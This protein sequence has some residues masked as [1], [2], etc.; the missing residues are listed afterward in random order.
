MSPDGAVPDGTVVVLV[1]G[2]PWPPRAAV[3]AMLDRCRPIRTVI[4]AD[5]GVALGRALGLGVGSV[6]GDL[7]SADPGDLAWVRTAGGS[8]IRYPAAKD[9]TDTELALGAALDLAPPRVL[10]LGG[11]AGRLD[12]LLG[13]LLLLAADNW[14]R[15]DTGGTQVRALLGPATITVVRADN[16]SGPGG[17]TG[18]DLVGQP[19][20]AVSLLPVGGPALGVFTSGLLYPLVGEDLLPGTS[21][22]ISNEFSLPVATVSL[23]GGTVIA[24]QPGEKSSAGPAGHPQRQEPRPGHLFRDAGTVQVRGDAAQ[25]ERPSGAE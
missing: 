21:R 7:D 9:A 25:V 1:G 22:G 19:G 5:S 13:I 8:I 15:K 18:A 10:L 14:D 6:I 20:G 11:S 23:R 12:H 17:G 3:S 4:A 16:R 24:V 2:Q